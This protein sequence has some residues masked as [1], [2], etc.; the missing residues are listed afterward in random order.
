[1]AREPRAP[2]E[3]T[4]ARPPGMRRAP[5]HQIDDSTVGAVGRI[6]TD[7]L[8]WMFT[9]N[10]VREYGI[11]G[12][13][14]AVREDGRITG[15]MLAQQIKGGASWFK[16]PLRDGSGWRFWADNDHLHYWLGY[17]VPV[18]VILGPPG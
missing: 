13:A 10:P 1:M 7:V 12:H 5:E 4:L 8:G 11:D 3:A 15:R 18:L 14:Q 16:R 2:A 9:P 6:F 17:H